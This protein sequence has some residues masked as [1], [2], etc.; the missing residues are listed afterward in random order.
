MQCWACCSEIVRYAVWVEIAKWDRSSSVIY[1]TR[2]E[3]KVK[4]VKVAL[5]GFSTMRP[6][7]L[8]YSYSQQLPASISRGA[9]H[10]TVA[11]DLYQ[12]RRELL[13]MNFAS[14]SL[15]YEIHEGL[16]HAAKLGHGTYYFTSPPK[17]GILRIFRTPEKSNGFG[18]VWTREQWPVY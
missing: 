3:I 16:L 17:E 7:G 14:R 4:Q 5:W 6:F 12:R 9:M 15:I 8:F 1:F 13:P 18:R 2:W 10:H 11:R